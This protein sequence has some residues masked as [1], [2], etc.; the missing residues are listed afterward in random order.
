MLD[1]LIYIIEQKEDT[2]SKIS[3]LLDDVK[4]K[5]KIFK[6]GTDFLNEY[7]KSVPSCA[8]IDVDSQFESKDD[9]VRKLSYLQSKSKSLDLYS[10]MKEQNITIPVIFTTDHPDIDVISLGFRAGALDFLERPLC[11]Q[12][13]VMRIKEAIAIDKFNMDKDE[14]FKFLTKPLET[15]TDREYEV[16]YYLSKGFSHKKIAK[17]LNISFRTVEAHT[18]RIKLKTQI[19]LPELTSSLIYSNYTR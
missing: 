4:F 6:K 19:P 17:M 2:A 10:E 8:I 3:A 15:L 16:V 13:L 7:K 1:S 11:Y 9:Q 5:Y 18:S 14:D 12:K